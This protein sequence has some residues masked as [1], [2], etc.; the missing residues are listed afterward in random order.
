MKS[1]YHPHLAPQLLNQSNILC[2]DI[3]CERNYK[4]PSQYH[5]FT[6]LDNHCMDGNI[7][8]RVNSR[9]EPLFGGE[10]NPYF[11][12]SSNHHVRQVNGDSYENNNMIKEGCNQLEPS[13]LRNNL[14]R[15]HL[16]GSPCHSES[17]WLQQR[18]TLPFSCGLYSPSISS[19][20]HHAIAKFEKQIV[21]KKMQI[22]SHGGNSLQNFEF[23]SVPSNQSPEQADNT[24]RVS[25]TSYVHS[26]VF[27][28]DG[29]AKFDVW[30]SQGSF[31]GGSDP[32]HDL[33]SQHLK[34]DSLNDVVGQI[35]I[36]AKDQNCC[37]F[38]Q[39]IFDKGNR[40]DFD[41][42][43]LAIIDH[44][45]ELTTDPFGNYFIQKLVEVCTEEQL[46]RIV[47]KISEIGGELLRI[48]FNQHGYLTFHN[49][50]Y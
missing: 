32:K 40:E 34:Y 29:S 15:Y 26:C 31:L 13:M 23:G 8:R 6:H 36:L 19:P 21:P 22:R 45:V 4:S 48:S 3:E 1:L 9:N 38:L 20:G 18:N 24:R 46:T 28:C 33:K 37:R 16:N 7:Q 2:S 47:Y 27:P 44:V 5:C 41:R 11:H 14:G 49:V 30:R 42:I 50:I 25:A 35:H 12:M 39:S 17:L 10:V 43:F